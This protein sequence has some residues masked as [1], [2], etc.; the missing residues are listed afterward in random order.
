MHQLAAII[1]AAIL[2]T[3]CSTVSN[4]LKQ[5]AQADAKDA[6]ILAEAGG[7]T[8][9]VVC[10]TAIAAIVNSAPAFPEGQPQGALTLLEQQRLS[11]ITTE[12]LRATLHKECAG[13]VVD[14]ATTLQ[15]FG[16][17]TIRVRP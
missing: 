13:V 5:T 7:D 8:E 14:M 15:N 9:A 3:G 6:L 11:R 17:M 16:I 4:Q 10:Y 12:R 1:F 2:L